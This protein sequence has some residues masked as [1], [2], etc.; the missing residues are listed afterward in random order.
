MGLKKDKSYI[1]LLYFNQEQL[2]NLLSFVGDPFTGERI[3]V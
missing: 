3:R 1:I 2:D